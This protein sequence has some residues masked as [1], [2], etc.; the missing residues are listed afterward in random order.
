MAANAEA[1]ENLE[2]LKANSYPG[3]GIVMGRTVTGK[4][5]QVYWVM[6][7][8]E[9][10][11]MRQLVE[12]DDVVK[13]IAVKEVEEAGTKKIVKMDPSEIDPEKRKLIIYNAMRS[14]G[15]NHVVSNG[16][17]TDGIIEAVRWGDTSFK[18]ALK[19]FTYEPDPNHTPRISGISYTSGDR[20]GLYELSVIKKAAESDEPERLIAAS[21]TMYGLDRGTGLAVHTYLGDAPEGELL[22]S[23][24]RKAYRLPLGE[25]AVDT[26]EMYWDTLN[27]DNRVA[28]A[29]KVIDPEDGNISYGIQN[30]LQ[31]SE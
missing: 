29:V 26:V 7:R 27:R 12:K 19:E 15:G 16:E 21:G 14:I 30:K 1:L 5:A 9:P 13:T 10:S 11:K 17:H 18:G 28:I 3:R 8:S 24:D 6:G 23:F 22:P 31:L 20:K 2:A 4:I 25:G